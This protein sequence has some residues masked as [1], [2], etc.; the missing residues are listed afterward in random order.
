M[1]RHR[2]RHVT[3]RWI[4]EVNVLAEYKRKL[5]ALGIW[6]Y[7]DDTETYLFCGIEAPKSMQKLFVERFGR[8][9]CVFKYEEFDTCLIDPV[10]I[11]QVES[12]W[13]FHNN[14]QEVY[15]TENLNQV[16]CVKDEV[17]EAVKI[18]EE[19]LL[20]GNLSDVLS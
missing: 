20:R 15:G 10:H 11:Y 19:Y 8:F 9:V 12:G 2:L 7:Y 18:C 5:H 1:R 14:P 3:L 17:G 6:S 13:A 4:R 16:Y